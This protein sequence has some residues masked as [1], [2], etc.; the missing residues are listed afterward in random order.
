[1]SD[2]LRDR[3]AYAIANAWIIG[4]EP[5]MEPASLD[6][7][8]ADAV[9]EALNLNTPVEYLSVDGKRRNSMVAGH[10]TVE[11]PDA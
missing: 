6:Y 5:G 2:N 8:M 3:I 1:M 9:I 11:V 10:Y 7:E 4:D